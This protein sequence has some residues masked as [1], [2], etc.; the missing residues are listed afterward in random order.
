[1]SM[2]A[3]SAFVRYCEEHGFDVCFANPGTSE[4]SCV[5]A[6]QNDPW[7]LYLTLHE[8]IAVGAADGYARMKQAPAL[9]LL[10][11]GV[12]LSNGLSNFHNA[13]HA[14]SN[15]L[16]VVGDIGKQHAGRGSVLETN[17]N[18]I[19]S[20]VSHE[21]Y[22][23]TSVQNI[24]Q[25][26]C[27]A[28]RS[29]ACRV[30]IFPQDLQLVSVDPF[31]G[32]IPTL[33]TGG[34]DSHLVKAS[35]DALGEN[36]AVLLGN[37]VNFTSLPS[38]IGKVSSTGSR[39]FCINNISRIDRGKGRARVERLSYFPWDVRRQMQKF[40][41]FILL[42]VNNLAANFS[43]QNDSSDILPT[44]ARVY[45]LSEEDT[46]AF[47]SRVKSPS[48]Q[49]ATFAHQVDSRVNTEQRSLQPLSLCKTLASSIPTDAILVDESLTSGSSFWELSYSSNR[50]SHLCLTGGAI[51]FG[52]PA[53][54]G[55]AVACP[56]RRVIDF[57]AD[58]S[59]MYSM[60]ALWT[61]ARN[62]LHVTT[63]ICNNAGYNILKLEN[64]I[65]KLP[66]TDSL[67]VLTDIDKPY[68]DWVRIAEG[69][70]VRAM[71]ASTTGALEMCLKDAL[72]FD[73]PVLIDA[74]LH[75]NKTK[76]D[77]VPKAKAEAS[78]KV[79]TK[80]DKMQP[81]PLPVLKMPE[82]Y[83]HHVWN[84]L[85]DDTAHARHLIGDN[86]SLDLT[87]LKHDA[88]RLA[89]ILRGEMTG[90][91]NISIF[92]WNCPEVIISHY[93]AAAAG[94][95]VVNISPR[96]AIAEILYMLDISASKTLISTASLR[97]Q[98]VNI[99]NEVE[100]ELS[101]ILFSASSSHERCQYEVKNLSLA[102]PMLPSD[103]VADENIQFQ[104]Y[105]TSGTTG[106]PKGVALTHAQVCVHAI[107][108]G[109][110]HMDMSS[111]DV[112]GHF[113]PMFHAVD[114]FSIYAISFVGG[115]HYVHNNS[116]FNAGD[117]LQAIQD[118]AISVTNFASSMIAIFV[119][120]QNTND[121]CFD[122]LRLVSCG[123][124]PI[125]SAFIERAF[126][127]FNCIFFVS[128]G[129]T[130]CCGK[131]AMSLPACR[132]SLLDVISMR[133]TAKQ[134]LLF[135]FFMI[136]LK[137]SEDQGSSG[138]VGETDQQSAGE[139]LVRGPT[140]CN[141]YLQ[142]RGADSWTDGWFHTGDI[143]LALPNNCL[144]I[145]D[146]KKDMLLVGGENVYSLE[147]EHVLQAHAAVHLAAVYGIAH[148]HLGEQ[149]NAAVVLKDG[150]AIAERALINFCSAR[151][152]SF[153]VPTRIVFKKEFPIGSTGKILKSKLKESASEIFGADQPQVKASTNDVGGSVQKAVESAWKIELQIDEIPLNADFLE[154]GGDS[155][156]AVRITQAVERDLGITIPFSIII[157]NATVLALSNAIQPI[158]DQSKEDK[159]D[160][161]NDDAVENGIQKKHV[162]KRDLSITFE[163]VASSCEQLTEYFSSDSSSKK[164][165]SDIC[166]HGITRNALQ[167]VS[168][169]ALSD[170]SYANVS[171]KLRLL[172]TIS[173][174]LHSRGRRLR[175]G[176]N[177]T[178]I[179]GWFLTN[180]AAEL[181]SWCIAYGLP[182]LLNLEQPR[183]L[184][185]RRLQV[186]PSP[187]KEPQM[188][189][190]EF[191]ESKV[192]DALEVSLPIFC[193]L[194][195]QRLLSS[196]R[197]ALQRWPILTGNLFWQYHGKLGVIW[198]DSSMYVPVFVEEKSCT[199]QSARERR[200]VYGLDVFGGSHQKSNQRQEI[201]ASPVG[202]AWH[203]LEVNIAHCADG[204]LISL[205]CDHSLFTQATLSDF[206][207]DWGK[208]YAGKC[209]G[210]ETPFFR[211]AHNFDSYGAVKAY[212]TLSKL[213]GAF[214][215]A[216]SIVQFWFYVLGILTQFKDIMDLWRSIREKKFDV[217]SIRD[218]GIWYR[219]HLALGLTPVDLIQAILC[220]AQATDSSLSDDTKICLRGTLDARFTPGSKV[221]P[222]A[223]GNYAVHV[224]TVFTLKEIRG[225]PLSAIA[226][227]VRESYNRER[228]I[229]HNVS[230][231]P[232]E[233]GGNALTPLNKFLHA[234]TQRTENLFQNIYLH[235]PRLG[236]RDVR[237]YICFYDNSSIPCDT[238]DFGEASTALFFRPASD[239][240][241]T[242]VLVDLVTAPHG[243]DLNVNASPKTLLL[244]QT[245]FGDMEWTISTLD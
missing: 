212:S 194:D 113:A 59:A 8:N 114:A 225:M 146:R 149:V 42:G 75:K 10:H 223:H 163:D 63:I 157:Q 35:I 82:K 70:G 201:V 32:M 89:G 47:A 9:V 103:I 24:S 178:A 176:G 189:H 46:A 56:S 130:E 226:L 231:R 30:L 19:A 17:L 93:A 90:N 36:C 214:I 96:L 169:D 197:D 2:T 192:N 6:L 151:L 164:L 219:K 66:Q 102:L 170:M 196:L 242:S 123:G 91:K 122:T 87:G 20:A 108:A 86:L 64:A 202:P 238:E 233:H 136:D 168:Y 49:N 67:S 232:G 94:V 166:R 109:I 172:Q 71:R 44:S 97:D 139:V 145:V 216:I 191:W 68:I 95:C 48:A 140:V 162:E 129:M 84:C 167:V 227:R 141:G 159:K 181:T 27:Q 40:E 38:D 128:Y 104:L 72:S 119:E 13:L 165:L 106:R 112:W 161:Q 117:A 142:G 203:V 132:P 54:I 107:A 158:F 121:M 180:L 150:M 4:M 76:E 16:V 143:A 154:L 23:V 51:G 92:M 160:A 12:G 125:S 29:D 60:Q 65:Q 207:R 131:I 211:F 195:E 26:C 85:P 185:G 241:T 155:L 229:T 243:F 224:D 21:V 144:K 137:I 115:V 235:P 126:E 230:L 245:L 3:I 206:I 213:N 62:N 111:K 28:C 240:R 99:E 183:T 83:P 234:W 15:I 78:E 153:K 69:M 81:D 200:I 228:S 31:R 1:M 25:A 244:L 100:N 61:Q 205:V 236:K 208:V 179:L 204:T 116:S 37:G 55:A 148:S 239:G 53:S 50:F 79:P 188:A 101:M 77:I 199:L 14:N 135:P 43:Y 22:E 118:H 105:F 80:L 222:S 133:E 186:R 98:I 7:R 147:V 237:K 209:I 74:I 215:L 127:L 45:R 217:V 88:L 190:L 177:A 152:A 124:S 210:D 220:K 221:P 187:I 218:D 11:T 175:S 171:S 34:V 193:N 156:T 52:M 58:G 198:G 174:E 41:I 73:G 134:S 18:D 110:V 138:F 33:K 173:D 182:P 184:P 57:Q 39:L 5:A 120:V